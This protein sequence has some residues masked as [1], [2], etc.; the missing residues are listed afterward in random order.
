MITDKVFEKTEY[1]IYAPLELHA[2]FSVQRGSDVWC[3]IV[4]IEQE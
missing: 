2:H 4:D 3:N 1:L